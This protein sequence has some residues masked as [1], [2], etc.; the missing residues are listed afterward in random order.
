M[1]QSFED[2]VRELA[3]SGNKIE[4]IK[5]IREETGAGLAEA[6]AAVEALVAGETVASSGT[7]NTSELTDEVIRLLERNEKIAAVKLYREQTG[8]GLKEAKEAVE[9]IA[10]QHGL[11]SASGAGCFGVILF[12]LSA[13]SLAWLL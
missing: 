5:R 10:E 1:D 3:A 9:A 8:T 11:A 7:T 13:T 6:K 2:E 4:A 12:L